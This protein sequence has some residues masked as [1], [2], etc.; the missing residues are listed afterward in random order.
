MMIPL[1]VLALMQA[2][3][4]QDTP[5]Q[6]MTYQ[7]VLLKGGP[8]APPSAPAEQQKMQSEHL[9][10]L[11]DLNKKRINMA[12]GPIL[13]DNPAKIRG[14]AILDVPS[15]DAAKAHF[16]NDPF[17]KAGVMVVD[18]YS[19]M[20]PRGWFHEPASTDVTNPANLEQLVFGILMRGP[21]TTQDSA[22]AAEIQ[23]GHLAYMDALHAKGKLVMAGPLVRAGDMRG[24][25]VYRVKDLAE[26]KALAADDPAVKAGRLTIDAHPWM[27]FKGILK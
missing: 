13:A 22:A 11:A 16:A 17:V 26:A 24:L 20:G 7:I 4:Q 6:M 19:W 18:V 23:K 27:T 14:I 10:L 5:G 3:P 25:V 8:N 15:A 2:A 21:T 12:Y 9:A 1:L